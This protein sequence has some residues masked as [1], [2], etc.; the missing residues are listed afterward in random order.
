MSQEYDPRYPEYIPTV[1]NL[2]VPTARDGRS[3]PSA[4]VLSGALHE[5]ELQ[6]PDSDRYRIQAIAVSIESPPPTQD[7]VEDAQTKALSVAVIASPQDVEGNMMRLF[8]LGPASD[9]DGGVADASEEEDDPFVVPKLGK[10][11]KK[12]IHT[13]LLICGRPQL[14]LVESMSIKMKTTLSISLIGRRMVWHIFIVVINTRS[15]SD[16]L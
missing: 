8:G 5:E 14:H 10:R 3:M 4:V 9:V 13:C 7:F 15:P 1:G 6:E 11:R 2:P 12:K 16:F